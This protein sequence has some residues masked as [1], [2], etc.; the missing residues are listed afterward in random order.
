MTPEPSNPAP[1]RATS[2]SASLTSVQ[3]TAV[4]ISAVVLVVLVALYIDSPPKT[5]ST[6]TERDAKH[7]V[8]KTVQQE[9]AQRSD[10][11]VV[12][13][14]GLAA[15]LG[16][17]ALFDGRVKLTGPG[18]AAIELVATVAAAD[19]AIEPLAQENELLREQIAK[20]QGHTV[21]PD[22][23]L[24]DALDRWKDIEARVRER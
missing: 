24:R 7:R 6:T 4:L 14:L 19:A 16:L 2:A 1:P 5:T 15:V 10:A 11:I 17:L 8:V 20:L 12:A 9:R 23:A 3:K 13:G 22:P 21:P 18:G